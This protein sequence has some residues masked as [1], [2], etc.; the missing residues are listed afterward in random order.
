[1]R[2]GGY[3]R[4]FGVQHFL[5][6]C[7]HLFIGSTLRKRMLKLGDKIRLLLRF[8]VCATLTGFVI[9]SKGG[10]KSGLKEPPSALLDPTSPS[11]SF[12]LSEH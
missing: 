9:P 4:S 8:A 7:W 10:I 3:W 12:N 6:S 2:L 5:K 11:L 1:M